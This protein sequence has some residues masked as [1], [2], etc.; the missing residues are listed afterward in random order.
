MIYQA[1]FRM[2]HPR[3]QQMLKNYMILL[4][5][6]HTNG[7]IKALLAQHE[8]DDPQEEEPSS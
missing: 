4:A 5:D 3:I 8:Q 6:L 2:E 7:D 1:S